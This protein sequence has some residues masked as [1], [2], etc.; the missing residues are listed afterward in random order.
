MSETLEAQVKALQK[1]V[2]TLEDIEAIQKLESI[3]FFS[4]RING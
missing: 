4:G 3:R 2:A 1:R